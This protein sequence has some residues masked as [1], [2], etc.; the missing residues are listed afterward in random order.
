MLCTRMKYCILSI[1]TFS[2]TTQLY[3]QRQKLQ[4]DIS[5]DKHWIDSVNVIVRK[6]FEE[7]TEKK[8][9]YLTQLKYFNSC[10]AMG[11]YYETLYNKRALPSN[12]KAIFYYEKIT[13]YGRFPDDERYFKALALR[14]NLCRI[15]ADIY[16]DGRG[17]KKNWNKS[18]ELALRG[19]SGYDGFF[20]Y[21]SKKYFGYISIFL[22][23]KH[24]PDFNADTVF[25][26]KIN[27]FA[28]YKAFSPLKKTMKNDLE[29]IANRYKMLYA[30]DTS[31]RIE[32]LVFAES[33]SR[34]Q[35]RAFNFLDMTRL[36][37]INK[38]GINP[39][40]IFTN[41]DFDGVRSIRILISKNL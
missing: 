4:Y 32:L 17:V 13:E 7:N 35:S 24:Q 30:I 29:R 41:I 40:H 16:F 3:A 1:V 11:R 39:D 31:Y 26:Y 5:A 20:E 27:P 28:F 18:I 19:S 34:S 23:Q 10:I 8:N 21:Y 12:R 25:E 14:N 2:F 15:L 37:F 36:F 22:K 6:G 33:S 38:N 9:N